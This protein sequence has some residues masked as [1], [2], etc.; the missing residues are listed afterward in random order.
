MRPSSRLE[1][2]LRLSAVFFADTVR[3]YEFS[4]LP[5]IRKLHEHKVEQGFYIWRGAYSI[6]LTRLHGFDVSLCYGVFGLEQIIVNKDGFFA[7][8]LTGCVK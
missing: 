4:I 1:N 3:T 2:L 8:F 5:R 7:F 6:Y